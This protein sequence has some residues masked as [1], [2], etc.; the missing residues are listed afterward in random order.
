VSG[1]LD[2]LLDR[3][4]GLP[5][6]ARAEVE[7]ETLRATEAMRWVPNPG[8]QTKAFFTQAD[9][10]L[11]GGEV[12]GGKALALDTPIATPDGWTTMGAIMPGD[13]VF[14]E[15]GQ[16]SRVV[17]VSPVMVNHDC[18][19]VRFSDGAE[20][21]A[22]AGHKWATLT[23]LERN[24]ACRLTEE[25]RTK[26]RAAR[27]SRAKD[28][29]QKP[30]VS[31]SITD[32]NMAREHT[33][34][35][36][37][38][39][40]VRTTA[41][42]AATVRRGQ[43]FNHSIAVAAPLDCEAKALPV[44]PYVLGAWLGDGTS[45]AASIASND[46]EIVEAIAA[47]GHGVTKW[48]GKFMYGIGG[49]QSDLRSLGVLKNKHI[50]QAYLR[51]STEQRLA[52]LQGLMDTDGT[53]DARGQ[54][55]F[56]TTRRVLA[57]GVAELLASL[58]VKVAIR[59]GVAKIAGREVG[60]K[61]SL[62]FLTALPVFRLARKLLRQKRGGFRGTHANRY[63]VACEP[64]ESVP[65]RCIAVDSPSRLYLAGR[66]MIPTHNTDLVLGL[67]L[68]R[69]K[70]SLLLRRQ[71]KEVPFLVERM[72]ALVGHKD[73]FNGSINRWRLPGG[74]MVQFGGCQRPGDEY[75]YK[76]EPK[77]LI[78]LDEASEFLES[79]V[80]FLVGWLRS[81][82]PAQKCRLVLATNPPGTAEGE[83]IVRWFAPWIDPTHPLYPYPDGKLLWC[84]RDPK[85]PGKFLWFESPDAVEVGGR[86]ITPISRTFIR[87]GLRDNPDYAKTDY[88][89]RLEA[90]PEVLRR[91]Y[92]KGDF[93][94]GQQDHE[95]Q[96][97]PTEW[98][99]AAQARWKPDGGKA[100]PMSAMALDPAGGGRDTAEIARRHGGWY[101]EMISAQGEETADGSKTAATLLG[102]RRHNCPVVV[103]AG[104]GYAGGVSL[105]LRDNAVPFLAF[106][107]A[108]AST[109]KTRD[110]LLGFANKRAE[111]WW[112]FMEELDPDQE[113]GSV[114]ALPP[115]AELRGDLAA[116]TFEITARGILLESK[117]EIRKR[118]GRSPGKGDAVVMAMSEGNRAIE[119]MRALPGFRAEEQGVAGMDRPVGGMHGR[120]PRVVMGRQTARGLS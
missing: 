48:A 58:G 111:V 41:E 108:K 63:I 18:Y 71:A 25:W 19:R 28:A 100:E 98:I 104:G 93:T 118:L 5:P 68:E 4:N 38:A 1:T 39:P 69:H 43:G 46:N 15:R 83:W 116:P 70:R 13:V 80:D 40:S 73:G 76:G 113:G 61:F 56:T 119:R 49:L 8:P 51:A 78:G 14:D 45:A 57:D 107:G 77:D 6:A 67:A 23:Q 42:I 20:I 59:E 24:Q 91:R 27:P 115:D 117:D 102:A 96:L 86:T 30:W 94:A 92:L 95:R 12:G 74:Q 54:C 32:V 53:A 44:E 55:E 85:A 33:Y 9:Q 89:D 81:P 36:P 87:S 64:V 90:L 120:A 97:I 103:D 31:L 109:R 82:D 21:V 7:A 105:R 29:S 79:Q 65:V 26:R 114:V 10:T 106:N 110:G 16:R 101:A 84:A 72:Q 75:G 62:K 112:R 99:I 17:A 52:L 34:K 2:S 66:A 11:Y 47:C 22:D 50:P 35:A 60:A 3:L 88:A 37:P